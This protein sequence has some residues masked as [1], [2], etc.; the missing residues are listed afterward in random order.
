MVSWEILPGEAKEE[1]YIIIPS[2]SSPALS[3][4]LGWNHKLLIVPGIERKESLKN[5][6]KQV[7]WV[8]YQETFRWLY[9]LV[10]VYLLHPCRC[11]FSFFLGTWN[12]CFLWEKYSASV[13]SL[14]SKECFWTYCYLC[15]CQWTSHLISSS[16]YSVRVTAIWAWLCAIPGRWHGQGA[17]QA[18]WGQQTFSAASFA[19]VRALAHVQC[20]CTH[21]GRS[22]LSTKGKVLV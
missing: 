14:F 4:L 2:E 3:S 1:R 18:R 16:Y 6:S 11:F 5:V 20:A 12:I 21:L 22:P 17:R 8:F 7:F 10:L 13:L 9:K 19:S 15:S